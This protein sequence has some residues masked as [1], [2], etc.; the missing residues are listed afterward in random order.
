[1]RAGGG[2]AV[3]SLKGAKRSFL[4]GEFWRDNWRELVVSAPQQTKT[5]G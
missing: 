2:Y 5:T 4:V 1:M 3:A